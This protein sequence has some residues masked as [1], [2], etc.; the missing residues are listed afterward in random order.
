MVDGS[1]NFVMNLMR[2]GESRI[3]GMKEMQD[4]CA[5]MLLFQRKKIAGYV[6][7]MNK[8]YLIWL[9]VLSEIF[10]SLNTL[11]FPGILM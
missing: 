6:K 2:Q 5:R 10:V 4:R 7:G 11:E 8:E 1:F 9:V 3:L